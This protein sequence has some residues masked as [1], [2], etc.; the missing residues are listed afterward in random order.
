MG[1]PASSA[2]NERISS[3]FCLIQTQLRNKLGIQKGA[4]LVFCYRM[5]RGKDEIEW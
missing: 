2:S 1:I 4:K 3:N 5:L